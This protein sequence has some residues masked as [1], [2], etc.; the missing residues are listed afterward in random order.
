MERFD[1]GIK[2]AVPL[3]EGL[4]A[5]DEGPTY[6]GEAWY[7]GGNTQSLYAIVMFWWLSPPCRVCEHSQAS[8][9]RRYCT[10]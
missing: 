6:T 7:S 10:R 4:F 5:E 8:D 9:C 2:S 1:S 3:V